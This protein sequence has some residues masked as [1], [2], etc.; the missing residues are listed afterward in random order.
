MPALVASFGEFALLSHFGDGLPRDLDEFYCC[1]L[2]ALRDRAMTAGRFTDW[3]GAGLGDGKASHVER[4]FGFV[5]EQRSRCDACGDSAATA[6]RY[7]FDRVLRLP[8]PE[9]A[10]RGR[11]WTTTELYYA[12]VAPT[13][14]ELACRRCSGRTSHREQARLLTQPNVLLLQVQRRRGRVHVRLAAVQERLR[15]R[16]PRL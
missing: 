15:T 11:V 1:L 14:V 12:R 10:E 9:S 6:V 13:E 16:A 3:A 4:L 5:L 8:V 2:D 7:S